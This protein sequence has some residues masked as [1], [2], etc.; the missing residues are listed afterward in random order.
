MNRRAF[1]SN[2]GKLPLPAQ[3][4]FIQSCASTRSDYDSSRLKHSQFRRAILDGVRGYWAC[5]SVPFD[6]GGHPVAV[7][8]R[9][10]ARDLG[11][12]ARGR[13]SLF[14]SASQDDQRNCRRHFP[15]ALLFQ[16]SPDGNWL[17]DRR[18]LLAG[19]R[20]HRHA[21][22]RAGECPHGAGRHCL[23]AQCIAHGIQRWLGDWAACGRAG[24]AFGV[25]LLHDRG[26]ADRK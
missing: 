23:A 21:R 4:F 11:R 8:D 2:A 15:F 7:G 10:D 1:V 13:Q 16:R 24:V 5:C 22:G 6:R 20:L 17:C 14:E 25:D 19:G 26:E 12:C 9:T 3:Q 18:F